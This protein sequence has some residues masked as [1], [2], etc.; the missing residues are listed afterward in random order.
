[1][2]SMTGIGKGKA[3]GVEVEIRSHNHRFLEISI[4]APSS[5][6]SYEPM[7]RK[8]LSKYITR[9]YVVVSIQTD[10]DSEYDIAVDHKLLRR[11][12]QIKN[13]L[14]KR[15]KI[16][17]NLSFDTVIQLPGIVKFTHREVARDRLSRRIL[18]AVDKARR[19][20]LQA[21]ALEGRNIEKSIQ[22]SIGTIKRLLKRLKARAPLRRKEKRRRLERLLAEAMIEATPKKMAE[23]ILYYVNR[24]DITEECARI[25]SH[26][27]LIELALKEDTPGRRI[28]F[29]IQELYREAN[30]TAAKA[31]DAR[32]SEFIVGI[33]EEVEKIREQ[34]QNVE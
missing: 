14:V 7:I 34:I 11:I 8:E 1:M 31:Y 9:G 3:T 12:V 5:V 29:L 4:K 13:L 26:I 24:L 16:Q 27:K 20:L 6:L 21:K 2:R 30:T 18:S 17:D 23:E 22:R 19:S 25:E 32:I 28:N 15:Y 10:G 33:K